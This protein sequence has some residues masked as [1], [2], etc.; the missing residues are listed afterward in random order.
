MKIVGVIKNILTGILSVAFFVFA[1]SMALILLNYN[2]YGVSQFDDKSLIIIRNEITSEKYK[3]GD[4]VIVQSK[5]LNNI[6]KGDEVFVYQ[7]RRTGG[8]DIDFGVVGEVYPDNKSIAF[9]NGAPYSMELVAGTPIKVYHNIGTYVAIITSKWGFLLSIL[10]PSFMI[11]IY[12]VYALI[13]EIKY[14]TEDYNYRGA[15]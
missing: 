12:Q 6:K 11:F 4:L 5:T 14:G 7:P 9:E 1:L 15:Y 10:V 8:V 13:V 2:K 3:K